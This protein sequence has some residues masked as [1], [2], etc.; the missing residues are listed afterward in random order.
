[1]RAKTFTRVMP[2]FAGIV[3][4]RVPVSL[5][6]FPLSHEDAPGLHEMLL[7]SSG[8]DFAM[9]VGEGL[10]VEPPFTKESEVGCSQK[11]IAI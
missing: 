6:S 3:V 2:P 8:V 7:V 4:G 10:V 1:M 9:G 11:E 5:N